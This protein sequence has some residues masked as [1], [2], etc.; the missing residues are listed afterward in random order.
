MF[1]Q[2]QQRN[3]Q[4]ELLQ[5]RV[6]VSYARRGRASY[7]IA[8]ACSDGIHMVF[9]CYSYTHAICMLYTCTCTCTCYMHAMCVQVLT[10]EK[11]QLLKEAAHAQHVQQLYEKVKD[12]THEVSIAKNSKCRKCSKYSKVRD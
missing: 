6:E 3:Q 10:Q 5:Q 7:A 11:V 2:A 9:A 1:G 4:L 8:R 12:Q